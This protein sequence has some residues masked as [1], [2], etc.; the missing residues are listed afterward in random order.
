MMQK[1]LDHTANP[2]PFLRTGISTIPITGFSIGSPGLHRRGRPSSL[3]QALKA[4]VVYFA[5]VFG[6]GFALGTI[7]TLSIVPQL[8]IRMSEFLEAP[9]MLAV[10]WMAGGWITGRYCFGKGQTVQWGVGLL[11]LWLLLSA[12]IILGMAVQGLSLI[13][14]FTKHDPVSGSVYYVLLGVFAAMPWMRWKYS[15]YC[16]A[17]PL[18]TQERLSAQVIQD[19]VP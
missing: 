5:L 7:R 14:V 9:F 2:L 12:E 16:L 3:V 17:R 19:I 1:H 4:G 15:Q 6:A 11:A 8:G 13:E 10:I 18:A